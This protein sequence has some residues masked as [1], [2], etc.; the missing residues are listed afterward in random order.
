MMTIFFIMTL[1]AVMMSMSWMALGHDDHADELGAASGIATLDGSILVVEDPAN[2]VATVTASKIVKRDGSA[3]IPVNA[4]VAGNNAIGFTQ[5]QTLI[6]TALV[7]GQNWK[8][9]LLIAEQLLDGAAGGVL[10]AELFQ[11][12]TNPTA[13]DTFIIKNAGL[14]E[15]YTFI[16]G[17]S[18]GFDVQIQG[19][20][21]L[22][23]TELISRINSQSA[24][25]FAHET[26]DLGDH[27]ASG[28]ATQGVVYQRT[29][30][31]EVNRIYGVQTVTTGIKVVEFGT[32][33][34]DYRLNSSTE[35]D[36]PSTDPA[37]AHFG[38]SRIFTGLDEEFHDE[39]ESNGIYRWDA[40]SQ[41]W[42]QKD[43][44]AVQG[45]DS[46][47]VTGATISV[48]AAVATAEQQ[49]G[50][51]VIN[52]TTDG[53]GTASADAGFLAMATDN[54][55]LAI[56]TSNQIAPKAG[57]KLDRMQPPISFTG[58]EVTYADL[59]GG[60]ATEAG[61]WGMTYKTDGSLAYSYIRW[62]KS[63]NTL[64][65]DFL[66]VQMSTAS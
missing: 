21:A 23:L 16:A 11:I 12:A 53:T 36:I 50:G 30:T 47:A 64:A 42:Q 56:N 66:A 39:R 29:A 60:G 2:A 55:V 22:T 24:Q 8:E 34:Q 19:T 51:L 4:T 20:A 27:F 14:T 52:R 40:T 45:G 54:A 17:A 3:D 10:G 46:I 6:N 5:A 9:Q 65:G 41:L 25:W 38:V 49:Y 32:G 43:T 7:A 59:D 48:N 1:V 31:E 28:E 26:S 44:G 58:A 13:T 33:T 63:A 57:A 18:S 37:V 62:Q 61:D 35:L 15:T